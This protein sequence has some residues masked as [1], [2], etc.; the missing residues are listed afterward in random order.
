ME[1]TNQAQ[2][3]E[4]VEVNATFDAKI[5]KIAAKFSFRTVKTKDEKTGLEV[6]NKRPTIELEL[7][8]ITV[9]GVVAALQAGGKQL[10]LVIEACRQVQLDRARELVN[11]DESVTSENFKYEEIS[12]AKIAELPKAQRRGGG[13]DKETWEAFGKDYVAV[14]P[15]ATGKS[16][17]QVTNAAKILLNKFQAVKNSKPHLK[18]LSEQLAIYLNTSPNAEQFSECVAFLV[19][20]ADTFLKMDD[21]DLLANL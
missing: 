15:A 2:D 19:G 3:Q 9:Q 6:E 11:E 4:G 20:K 7:P 16:E 10:E 8:L 18:L 17:E 12:W 21:A 14:M 1:Q 5:E 13:I